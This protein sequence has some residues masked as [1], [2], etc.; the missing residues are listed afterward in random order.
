MMAL[1]TVLRD[2]PARTREWIGDGD[3]QIDAAPDIFPPDV[4]GERVCGLIGRQVFAFQ[5]L[6]NSDGIVTRARARP[7]IAGSITTFAGKLGAP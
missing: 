6:R 5:Y 2:E 7:L 1:E 4:I 3:H